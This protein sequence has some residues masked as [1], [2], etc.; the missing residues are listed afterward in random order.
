MIHNHKVGTLRVGT[1]KAGA[2]KTP[3]PPPDDGT[4]PIQTAEVAEK[5]SSREMN[6][7]DLD[8]MSTPLQQ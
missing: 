8:D 7:D 1:I 5:L 2:I 6:K 4:A 3:T